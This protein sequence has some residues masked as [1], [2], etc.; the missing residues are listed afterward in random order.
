MQQFATVWDC[1]DNKSG[2]MLDSYTQDCRLV[3]RLP[4][5]VPNSQI[6]ATA[7]P[8]SQWVVKHLEV[9]NEELHLHT[10]AMRS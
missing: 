10:P 8:L 9:R 5:P 4:I 2:T 7:Q 3:W 6:L 1:V